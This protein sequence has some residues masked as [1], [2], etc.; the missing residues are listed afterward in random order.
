MNVKPSWKTKYKITCL[1]VVGLIVSVSLCGCDLIDYLFSE[2]EPVEEG[3]WFDDDNY[4]MQ[5]NDPYGQDDAG[6]RN[7][8][9]Y[10]WLEEDEIGTY[11]QQIIVYDEEGTQ[12]ETKT[13]VIE[14][15]EDEISAK[16]LVSESGVSENEFDSFYGYSMLDAET[17]SIYREIAATLTEMKTDV[18][19]STK[20][21]E[22][23]DKAFNVVMMDHPEIFYVTGYSLGK[24]T[25]GSKIT[26]LSFT[27]TYT[28]PKEQVAVKSQIIEDY[29]LHC[30]SG[31]SSGA[32]DYD[33]VKYVYDYLI[34]NVEYDIYAE[35]N[36][37]ILGL[38][39]SG[40]T[41]CQGYAKMT[42][43]LLNRLGVFATLASG[44]ARDPRSSISEPHSWNIVK[45]D[46]DFYNLDTTWGD[47]SYFLTDDDGNKNKLPDR[48]YDY[49]LVPDSWI[50]NSHMQDKLV[51]MPYCDSLVDN[52]YVKTGLY[53]EKVDRNQLEEAFENAYA[54]G[55]ISVS[56]KCSDPYVFNEMREHLIGEENIFD[57]L[58]TSS[59]RY[60]EYPDR[61]VVLIYL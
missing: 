10:D 27:G 15:M 34:D 7:G 51:P 23:I 12:I 32:G 52:Y 46:G 14:D 28:M 57:Y 37:N 18:I 19:V 5:Q 42:Q 48:L 20:D 8:G 3:G 29:V 22:V 16:D 39:E 44:D 21:P 4:E 36:Q 54:R 55:E 45:V 58:G 6:T 11:E 40:T 59:V 35:N 31:I 24:Y 13:S 43:Y 33:K 2:D 50:E 9:E 56:I 60:V 47:A 30:L 53:F 41:V 1:C 38:C 49:F 17:Q 26:K 25:I 61:N